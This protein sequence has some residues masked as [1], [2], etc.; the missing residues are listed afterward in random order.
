MKPCIYIQANPRQLVGALIAEYALR[1]NSAHADEF[2]TRILNIEDYAIFADHQGKRYTRGGLKW[3]WDNDDL[4]S[5]TLTRFLPPQ[6]MGFQG[7]ALV[8]DP[9]V[10][11]VGDVWPL[12]DRDM[13]GKAILCRKRSGTKGKQGCQATSV[14][15]LDCA[16]LQHWRFDEDFNSLFDNSRDYA[17]WICLRLEDA[18][19]LGSFEE[20]W[21]DFDHLGKQTMMLHTTKRKTQPWKTGLPIDFRPLERFRWFPPRDWLSR[22]RRTLFGDYAFLGRYRQNPDINQQNFIF[23]LIKECIDKDIISKA[24]LVEEMA[25]KHI[26]SDAFEVLDRTPSLPPPAWKT[27]V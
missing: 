10:F 16:R 3:R 12:L 18:R 15:L 11:A 8:I 2:E 9:D 27:A 7:R 4:Q 19:N 20:I 14:M 5:F 13:G 17:D 21:N 22:T 26:R 6:E 23:G 25:S 1:R 24:M